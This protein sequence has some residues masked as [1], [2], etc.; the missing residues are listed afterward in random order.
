MTSRKR[1]KGKDRKA[2]KAALEAE[3]V[4]SV[5]ELVRHQWHAWARGLDD[6]GRVIS[7]CSHGGALIIPDD[8][9]HPV[10]SFVDTFFL[11]TAVHNMHTLH[12]MYDTFHKRNILQSLV[13]TFQRH[14]EV[15][16]NESYRKMAIQILVH[17]GT[18]S[19]HCKDTGMPQEVTR[20]IVILENYDGVGG[21]DSVLYNPIASKKLRDIHLAGSSMKRDMLKFYRKR[22]TCS[23][24]KGMHLEAR[25]T[26]PKLGA[27]YL[28]DEEKERSLLMVCGRCKIAQ[29]CSRECQIA[30]WPMHKS[31]C[32]AYVNFHKQQK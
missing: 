23:C 20:A 31:S 19:L 30:A 15:W 2:K 25:K 7:P 11:N 10:C 18:T 9:N 12:N 32:D 4:D 17:C 22:I 5:K 6:S 1:N 3:K 29:Y 24:L 21:I 8:K 26:L 28:C 14:A 13:D 27:C 16:K